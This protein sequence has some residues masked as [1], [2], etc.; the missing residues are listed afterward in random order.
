[1]KIKTGYK[2]KKV[3]DKYIVIPTLEESVNFSGIMT[4]NN[5][6]KLLFEALQSKKSV[7]DLIKL[8][9]DEYDID[10]NTARKDINSFIEKLKTNN[11]LD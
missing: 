7:E 2:I 8:L 1:M 4:L 11:L 6:G 9:T 3:S 10:T 5:S